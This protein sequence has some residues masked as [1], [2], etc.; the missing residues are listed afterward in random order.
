MNK[1]IIKVDPSGRGTV[2]LNGTMLQHVKGITISAG[3]EEMTAVVVEF[4]YCEVDAD[5]TIAAE[6]TWFNGELTENGKEVS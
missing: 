5:V 3:V 6:N 1:F 2:E 4:T